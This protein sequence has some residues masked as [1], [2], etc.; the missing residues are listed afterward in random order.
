MR[1]LTR[2]LIVL[3]LL[4]A[5]GVFAYRMLAPADESSPATS[6]VPALFA[7]T[8]LDQDG[9]AQPLSQWR[10]KVVV[11]NFWATWCPPCKEEMPE[12]SAFQQKYANRNVVVLGLSTDDVTK[13]REFAQQ[14]PV[15]YPL[16]A[17]DFQA[18][19][20]AE[21]LGN[22]KGVLPYSVVI[23]PDENIFRTYFG[24]LDMKKLEQDI[25]A[26]IPA[27]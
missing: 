18:M 27:G 4:L 25:K 8:F 24:R 7:A 12:L 23:S 3:V 26:L 16:L 14:A 20:L 10:G 11:V 1:I 5:A 9:K 15:Q 19:A 6:G 2:L 22:N 21:S 17:G 13:I